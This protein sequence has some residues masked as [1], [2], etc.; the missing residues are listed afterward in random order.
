MATAIKTGVKLNMRWFYLDY[1]FARSKYTA[2][3]I[4]MTK[5]VK[6]TQRLIHS[7]IF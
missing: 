4:I 5:N 1:F 2:A 3:A 7:M 6:G